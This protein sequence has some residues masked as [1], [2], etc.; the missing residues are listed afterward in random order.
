MPTNVFEERLRLGSAR[1]KRKPR[2]RAVP[3]GDQRGGVFIL[4]DDIGV[5]DAAGIGAEQ[6]AHVRL[7]QV[8]QRGITENSADLCGIVR[9][10]DQAAEQIVELKV[11][12]GIAGERVDSAG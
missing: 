8:F 9:I 6:A 4:F 2:I 3:I 11:R 5:L 7:Q 1:M 10:V 12:R